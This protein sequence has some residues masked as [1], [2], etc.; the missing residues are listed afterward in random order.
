MV[1]GNLGGANKKN[2]QAGSE[3]NLS[4]LGERLGERHGFE[5]DFLTS[6]YNNAT[7]EKKKIINFID[8]FDSLGNGL[9]F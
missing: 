5:L 4:R 8:A 3:N 7:R 1:S 6:I 9:Y 2:P